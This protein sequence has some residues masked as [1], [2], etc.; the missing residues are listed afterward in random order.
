ML[1]RTVLW[2]GLL[3]STYFLSSVSSK[4]HLSVASLNTSVCKSPF[5]MF[6]C[7]SLSICVCVSWMY[8]SMLGQGVHVK[9]LPLPFILY[10][11][12]WL[13]VSYWPSSSLILIL[14]DYSTISR[15]LS[16]SSSPA[17]E[18]QAWISTIGF[19][20]GVEDLNADPHASWESIHQ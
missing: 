13:R 10:L 2:A 11:I 18:L 12:F 4:I 14:L 3:N 15:D 5:C 16:V 9:F 6:Y 1:S 8:R 20:V 19:Y 7:P 17:L